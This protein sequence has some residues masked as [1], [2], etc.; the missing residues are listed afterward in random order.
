MIGAGT[1]IGRRLTP[2]GALTAWMLREAMRRGMSGM[3]GVRIAC[4]VP[5]RFRRRAEGDDGSGRRRPPFSIDRG[6]GGGG[7]RRRRLGLM[8]AS[9]IGPGPTTFSSGG[10]SPNS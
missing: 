9:R 7:A 6:G 5:R 2:N 8:G 3:I 4:G 1:T 10:A